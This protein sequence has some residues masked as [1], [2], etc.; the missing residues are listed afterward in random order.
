MT[1]P[2]PPDPV[3]FVARAQQATNSAD[4]DWA[5]SCYAP[6]I[7]LE[8]FGDGLHQVHEGVTEVRDAVATIYDWLRA[9]DGE[10]HKTLVAASGNVLVNSWEGHMFGGRSTTY[11]AEFWYFDDTGL[12]ERNVLYQSLNPHGLRHPVTGARYLVSHPRSSVTYLAAAI[13]TKRR[14]ART[15]TQ[16]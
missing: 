14:R 4:V 2:L 1:A 9:N 16:Q 12:V 15:P 3:A 11:G 13:R 8:T 7:T 6:S 10:V 5:M